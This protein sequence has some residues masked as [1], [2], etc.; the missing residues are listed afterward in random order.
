[1]CLHSGRLTQQQLHRGRKVGQLCLLQ[2]SEEEGGGEGI[3]KRSTVGGTVDVRG[4]L[5][6]RE[7]ERFGINRILYKEVCSV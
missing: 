4:V 6:E 5:E 2:G 1:M 7:E 3:D